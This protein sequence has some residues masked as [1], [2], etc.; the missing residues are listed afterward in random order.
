VKFK[1]LWFSAPLR[2]ILQPVS[3]SS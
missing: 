3:I 1:K 2:F